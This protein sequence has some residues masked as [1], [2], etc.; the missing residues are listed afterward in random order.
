MNNLIP[1]SINSYKT[2]T[3]SAY[4]SSSAFTIVELLVVIVVIG[5]LAAISI[6][7]YTGI[8]QKATSASLQFDLTNASKQLK[9]DQAVGTGYPATLAVAND[10]KGISASSGTTY[11]YAVDNNVNPQTFCL[12][13]TKNDQSYNIN[14]DGTILSGGKNLITLFPTNDKKNWSLT[15]YYL[16]Y[17]FNTPLKANTTYTF[18]YSYEVISGTLSNLRVGLGGGPLNSYTFDYISWPTTMLSTGKF[19]FTTPANLVQPYF[20]FRPILDIVNLGESK[21]VDFWNIK[22][23]EGTNATCWT[24]SV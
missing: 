21:S 20:Q 3:N 1:R 19:T 12:T 16:N 17:Y 6:V 10:N 13:A 7:S 9:M 15:G 22:L 18:S 23:E 14:Q 24:P 4:K 5:V 11:Q 2:R 8:T